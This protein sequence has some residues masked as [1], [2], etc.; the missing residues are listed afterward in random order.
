MTS[1][2]NLNGPSEAVVTYKGPIRRGPG[3]IVDDMVV[4]TLSAP[5]S[6]TGGPTGVTQA[7]N[8]LG[9]SSCTDWASYA[10]VYDEFRVLA[11]CVEYL[12]HYPGGNSTVIHSA[13]TRFTTHSSETF[14]NPSVDAQIQHG[15]WV[16]IHSGERYKAEWRMNAQEEAVFATTTSLPSAVQGS[17]YSSM[18]NATSAV[19]YGLFIN[20]WLVQFRGRK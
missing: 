4:A 10:S 2:K 13:G 15:D 18:L 20:T 1:A 9:V 16:A 6:A 7:I 14:V 19:S 5:N 11:F 8:N 12:P 3:A 17:I